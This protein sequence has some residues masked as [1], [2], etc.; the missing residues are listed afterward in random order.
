M[1]IHLRHISFEA[2][3]EI[4][5]AESLK[6]D[7]STIRAA[8]NDFSNDKKLGQ[9][10]FG[11]VYK[12]QDSKQGYQEFKN[13]VL[14]LAKLQHRN[15][16][17]LLGFCLEGMEKVL[18]YEFMENGSLDH[19]IFGI[20]YL[21]EDSQVRIIHR[22]LKPSNVLL[23]GAMNSKIADFGTARLFGRDETQGNTNR[24]AGTFFGVLVL[25]I[26][27]GQK[28]PTWGGC[29]GTL[30]LWSGSGS[31]SDML[32]CIHIGLLCVQENAVDRP[33]MASIVLMLNSFP[34]TLPTPSLHFTRPLMIIVRILLTT[35]LQQNNS[36]EIEFKNLS[37]SK[38]TL[39]LNLT[40]H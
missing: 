1:K 17:R 16:V 30:E 35:P 32:R 34:L 24:I 10:G 40:F 3:N 29:G 33:T 23:D 28:Y 26:I 37:K 20:L 14:L 18:I 25:E 11:P 9:C 12:S 2:I 8:A 15:L 27:S 13:E 4:K 6:Y 7:L 38:H 36:R 21:H 22:D 19:F 5:S 39:L 31:I